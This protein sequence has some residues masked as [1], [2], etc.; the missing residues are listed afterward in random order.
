MKLEEG[1][2]EIFSLIQKEKYRQDYG[3]E[4]IASENFTTQEVMEALGSCLT[5]KYSE[6]QPGRRYY[7][8]NEVIDQV[9]LL[10]KKRALETFHVSDEE[11]GVN[12]QPYSGSPANFAVF[13]ALLNPYDRLM[14][15]DL[16]SGGHLSHGYYTASGKKISAVSKYFSSMPYQ[17]NVETERIDYDDLEKVALVYRPKIIIG[18]ASAYP[19]D[20]DWERLRQ[21]CNKCGAYLLADISHI[22]GLVCTK[23]HNNPFEFVDIVT[24][25]THKTLRGPRS[26]LIFHKKN[27]GLE[28]KIDSAVFPGLQGGPHNHQ[29]AAVAVALKKA[30]QPDFKEYIQQVK[31]NAK[32]LAQNLMDRGYK[33]MTDGTDNHLILLNVRNKGIT[34]SKIEKILDMVHVTVNKNTILGDKNALVP[35]GIRIGTPACTSRGMKE[36]EFEEIGEII[37]ECIQLSIK[38]QEKVGKKLVDFVKECE[39][40]E[41]LSKIKDRVRALAE[42]FVE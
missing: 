41:E 30:L 24:T 26:A 36:E 12:V 20:I 7:G 14:G 5:N 25:T 21:I 11:W 1:D 35:G 34:G 22:S 42:R 9:E 37:H 8:G 29:I 18:G 39:K 3:L 23:E 31:K 13:T 38:I 19:R 15:L 10:C 32:V 33:V 16:P 6:G 28:E 27:L 4:L 40:L 17:L 2:P